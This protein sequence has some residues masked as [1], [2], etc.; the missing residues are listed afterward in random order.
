MHQVVWTIF[1]KEGRQPMMPIGDFSAT[2]DG[3]RDDI[4]PKS[5]R[6]NGPP[7][8]LDLLWADRISL[9]ISERVGPDAVEGIR[10]GY[11]RAG[12]MRGIVGVVRTDLTFFHHCGP[13]ILRVLNK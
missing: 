3:P 9:D 7:E 1:L 12:R 10:N 13:P 11:R 2:I 8:R 4:V 5:G 6:S